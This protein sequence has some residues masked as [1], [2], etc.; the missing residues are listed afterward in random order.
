MEK[1]KI[2]FQTALPQGVPRSITALI[3]TGGETEVQRKCVSVTQPAQR[4]LTQDS[5]Q[6]VNPC[7]IVYVCVCVCAHVRMCLR[8]CVCVHVKV[9][10][11]SVL[12]WLYN[13]CAGCGL[14]LC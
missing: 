13:H 10:C 5:C 12:R 14:T 1:E 4:G 7:E 3:V 9:S 11:M 2:K 6:S 8:V